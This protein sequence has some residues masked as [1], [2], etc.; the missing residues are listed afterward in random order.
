MRNFWLL[1][2]TVLLLSLPAP[3]QNNQLTLSDI[4]TNSDLYP[5]RLNQL[6]WVPDRE[7]YAYVSEDD[8]LVVY[9]LKREELRVW[10]PLERLNRYLPDSTEGLKRFPQIRWHTASTFSFIA[11]GIVWSYTAG[12]DSLNA[13]I[14]VPGEAQHLHYTDQFHY[15]YVKDFNLFVGKGMEAPKQITRDGSREIAYG[16]AA[17]RSEFGIREGI[18]WEKS[19][20]R[21]AFYRIDQT[22]I[23]DYPL[24]DYSQ[25]PAQTQWINYPMNGD[26]SQLTTVGI[27]N[28]QSEKL[29]YLQTEG[30]YDQYFT[31]LTWSP[32][33]NY[34]YTAQL[35]RGQDTMQLQQY[36]GRS[37][38]YIKTLFTETDAQYVEPEHGPIFLPDAEGSF[39]W[40]SERDGYQHLY[41][42]DTDGYLQAQ[43]TR[44]E[45]NV[46][47]YLGTDKRERYLFVN[48]TKDSPLM[49]TIYKV[50]IED[51]E[52]T[53]LTGIRGVHYGSISSSGRYLLD[54][55]SNLKT[56][57]RSHII[58]TRNGEIEK[59]VH[60]SANPLAAYD[61][62]DMELVTLQAKDGTDL[63]GRLIKPADFSPNKK[64][65]AIIYVY[66]GPHVQLVRESWLGNA[67]LFL[68]YLAQ[69]GYVVFTLDSR[70]SAG[71]SLAFEQAIFRNMGTLE[72]ADQTLV[73]AAYLK[74][75]P[76][77][78]DDRIGVHGWSYGGFM[79]LSMLLR[80]PDQFKVGVAGGP[81]TDWR[82]YEVM[83]GERYMD[84]R[85]DNPQGFENSRLHNYV[86]ALEGKRVLILHG[87]Q[88]DVVLPQHS[89]TFIREAIKAGQ[90]VDFFPYPSHPHNVR[91]KDRVH[92]LE[93]ITDYFNTHL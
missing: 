84:H 8:S 45:W 17:Y 14:R 37:G 88:D 76:W 93:K 32:D 55:Y 51:G 30:P 92:L 18:F 89:M 43:L 52:M 91:G 50:D 29:V 61:M 11:G 75:Q 26:S 23:P 67:Q 90:Q 31:N 40:F 22:A 47:A 20:K 36:D 56:P 9:D 68:Y 19:G 71:R 86:E 65:P 15:A 42:Y 83:Y 69:Q 38:V 2:S 46:T 77:V 27:Y 10:L 24:T 60:E 35:N 6:S 64:Y 25:I 53:R 66:G 34:L 48:T 33:G 4:I 79:T 7:A 39:L 12:R 59:V 1:V 41:R 63:Y 62:P 85:K 81:V 57:W 82:M 73:G 80:Q 54:R 49:R 78:D 28:T 13:Q 87:L 16:I 21:L 70:G 3:A 58:D 44:G 74:E 72:V 5:D